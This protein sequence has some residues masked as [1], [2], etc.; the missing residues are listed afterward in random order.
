MDI[1]AKPHKIPPRVCIVCTGLPATLFGPRV[2][3]F[4]VARDTRGA[5]LL[6]EG[7]REGGGKRGDG[8]P[9]IFKKIF[10]RTRS[11]LVILM[12]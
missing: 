2:V 6:G 8:V 10:S 12:V 3:D 7:M 11:D 9:L 5:R 1:I 4:G